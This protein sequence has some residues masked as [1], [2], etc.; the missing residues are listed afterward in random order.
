VFVNYVVFCLVLC[1]VNL[2]QGVT[3][4]G[5]VV[6]ALPVLI[7]FFPLKTLI[8]A[9]VAVNLMQ[10]AYFAFT[11]RK[12]IHPGHTKSIVFL[13]LAGL[14]VGYAIYRYVPS[15]GLKVAL[16]V[17]VVLVAVW[18]LAGIDIGRRVPR[19]AYHALNFMGGVTQGALASGGPFLVIYAARM[20]KDKSAF[21]ASL[22][23]VWTVLNALLC[24]FY[25]A[26]RSWNADMIPLIGLAFPCL[27]L[28]TV[29]GLILH[30]RI[31]QKPF[32]T[33]VFSI[34]LISGI[35][36]LRPLFG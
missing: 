12:H 33:M 27:V 14:P 25:T 31:P 34:L 9:L 24:I 4:F 17:F 6:L 23:V 32:R 7:Y 1:V 5:A 36:L 20:L 26:T 16:G 28:G 3:G 10:T 22:S 8:P 30:E 21:R 13:S 2:I 35:I 19:P 11:Q 29:L 15:E 18:N